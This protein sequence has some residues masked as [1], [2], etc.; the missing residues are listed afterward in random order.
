M[1]IM[2]IYLILIGILLTSCFQETSQSIARENLF[3]LAIGKMEDQIDLY[4]LE[5]RPAARKTSL[6]M[7]D[8]LVY[9][10]D[11]NGAKLL[12]FTSYGDLLSMI[13]N[14]ERNPVPVTLKTNVANDEIVTR[15]AWPY[16]LHQPG[17]IAVDSRKHLFVEERLEPDRRTFNSE[18]GVQLDSVILHFNQDGQFL[19]Y[20]GQEGTGGTPFPYILSVHSVQNNELVVICRV[21][22]AWNIHWFDGDANLLY[23][24]RLKRDE[25]PL[26]EDLAVIPSLE[27]MYPSFENK[28]LLMKIDYYREKTDEQTGTYAGIAYHSSLLWTMDIEDGR[29]HIPINLPVYEQK[30][31]INNKTIIAE[32]PYSFLGAVYDDK[33][34][35]SAP[36]E[37]GYM[38]IMMDLKTEN[39]KRGT[40]RVDN[41]ELLFSHFSLSPEGILSAMLVSDFDVKIAWWRTDRLLGESGQ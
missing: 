30:E 6:L 41:E 27:V 33:I 37:N 16:Q 34:F 7:R 25:L 29:F 10:S 17:R 4:D 23:L 18:E 15:R 2:P 24:I 3:S 36:Q 11:A 38:L 31:L 5:N 35:L 20:I 32:T 12:R 13:Y 8:G 14:P 26:P 39:Q 19:Q 9:I 21:R 40:I 1:R 22:D 28:K